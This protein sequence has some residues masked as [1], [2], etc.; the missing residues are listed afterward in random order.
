MCCTNAV[1]AIKQPQPD[2]TNW[3]QKLGAHCVPGAFGLAPAPLPFFDPPALLPSAT[4]SMQSQRLCYVMLCYVMLCYV[5]LCYVMLCYVI[6]CY[7][8]VVSL[9]ACT[10]QGAQALM[11]TCESAASCSLVPGEVLDLPITEVAGNI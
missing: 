5:M 3:K 9:H 2:K 6:L 1:P 4:C 10:L 7:V 8:M 11:W